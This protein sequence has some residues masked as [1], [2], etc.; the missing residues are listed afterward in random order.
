MVDIEEFLVQHDIPFERIDHA[1]VFTCEESERLLPPM[2][3]T[4]TKNLFLRDG[5]EKRFFLIVVG[6]DTMVDLKALRNMLGADKLSFASAER[7]KEH[8]GVEPGSATLLGLVHDEKHAVE[9]VIDAPLWE[10]EALQCHPL[11]NTA[12]M[13]IEHAGIAKF[14][15]ATGHV[16][17]V[18]KVPEREMQ[19]Q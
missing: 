5:K 6:H 2:P 17:C 1:A 4:G 3:G 15:E 12:T 7:L 10:S 18:L 9:V 8:L 16:Y 11:I 13:V 14:L 19:Q